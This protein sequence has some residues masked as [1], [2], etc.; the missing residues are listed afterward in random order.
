MPGEKPKMMQQRAQAKVWVGGDDDTKGEYENG[1]VKAVVAYLRSMDNQI[2]SDGTE[3]STTY[4]LQQWRNLSSYVPP[5][6]DH[7][8]QLSPLN[9]D[10]ADTGT[11]H[12]RAPRLAGAP[13]T[14][15][16]KIDTNKFKSGNYTYKVVS[17]EKLETKLHLMGKYGDP[18]YTH[19]EDQILEQDVFNYMALVGGYND[20][21]IV[22]EGS[23]TAGN[24]E[25]PISITALSYKDPEDQVNGETFSMSDFVIYIKPD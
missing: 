15:T 14:F 22:A 25:E 3:T 24:G 20:S 18:L 2:N 23:F 11:Q 13:P 19:I 12:L 10:R 21:P 8:W 16:F 4:Q 5:D 7:K 1:Q 6:Y 9:V 17:F